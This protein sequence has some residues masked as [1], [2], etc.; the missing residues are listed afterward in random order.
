MRSA[1]GLVSARASSEYGNP[2]WAASQATGEPD[3]YDCGD[4]TSAWASYDSD[5]IEW[6]E[7]TY[8]T[9]VVPTSVSI[10]QN[11]NPSQVV[12]VQLIATNGSKYIAWS[13]YPENI[14]IC[15]DVMEITVEKNILVNKVR[16]TI[17][18]RVSGWGWNE[19]DAVELVGTIK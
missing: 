6:I 7:L 15:P 8:K 3:V 9:P 10:Y 13:G 12:E 16:I 1:S 5:T 17:D 19:M 4:N 11:Y 18:Q 2:D 14:D